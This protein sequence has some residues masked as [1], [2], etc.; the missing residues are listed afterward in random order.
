MIYICLVNINDLSYMK[1]YFRD[2]DIY[3][4]VFYK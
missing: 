4:Y 3:D 2:V 1:C